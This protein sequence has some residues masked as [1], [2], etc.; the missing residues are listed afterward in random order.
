L[1]VI[2]IAVILINITNIK[3]GDNNS[4]GNCTAISNGKAGI[5]LTEG[6]D[7]NSVRGSKV[8]KNP[9]GILIEIGFGNILFLNNLSENEANANDFCLNQWDDG[10]RGNYYDDNLCSDL[11]NDGLC[12][13]EHKI[14]GG[15]SVDRHPLAKPPL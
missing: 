9:F 8:T 15:S 13:S 5:S 12:D 14:P 11:N 3:S 7:N 2:I 4:L 6:A 10:I 1:R